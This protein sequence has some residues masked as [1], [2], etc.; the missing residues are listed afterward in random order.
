MI[1]I[2]EQFLSFCIL[3]CSQNG[4][5]RS[6]KEWHITDSKLWRENNDCKTYSNFMIRIRKNKLYTFKNE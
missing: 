6:A 4:G 3:D 2:L 1:T 5:P